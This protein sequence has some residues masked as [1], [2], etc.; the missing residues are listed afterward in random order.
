MVAGPPTRLQA[1]SF[2]DWNALPRHEYSFSSSHRQF[3][4]RI[5]QEVHLQLRDG[6]LLGTDTFSQ[7]VGKICSLPRFLSRKGVFVPIIIRPR[8][9]DYFPILVHR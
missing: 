3:L 1:V 8:E 4:R 6:A 5:A 9:M 7:R 2:N